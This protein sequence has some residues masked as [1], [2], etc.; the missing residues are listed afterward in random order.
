MVVLGGIGVWSVTRVFVQAEDPERGDPEVP[1]RDR[2][3]GPGDLRRAGRAAR[4]GRQPARAWRLP[5]SAIAA[6]PESAAAAFGNV[7]YGLTASAALQGVAVGPAGVAAVLARA[8]A[9][10]PAGQAA[11]AVAGAGRAG[12]AGGPGRRARAGSRPRWCRR[13]CRAPT[14][15]RS[16]PRFSSAPR[17]SRS[18]PGRRRRSG[19]RWSSAAGLPASAWCSTASARSSCARRGRS[20]PRRTFRCG[21]RWSAC[22]GPGNQ[23][24][25]ILLAVGLGSFFVLGVRALQS[26]LLSQFSVQLQRGGADMFLIDIQQ[27]QVDGVRAFV[28]AAGISRAA[29]D[30]GAAR[31]RHRRS[32]PRAQPRELRGRARPRRRWAAST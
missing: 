15:S 3:A 6:I 25:V 24:R 11:A 13:G 8:A 16:A 31:P 26:N 29:A 1:R 18:P 23:T 7:S 2:R 28:K 30:S 5:P 9:R 12:G 14:R 19:S 21:T 4:A 10:G 22:G 27:D 17:S 20:P 32:R